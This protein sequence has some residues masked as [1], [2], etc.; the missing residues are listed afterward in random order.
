MRPRT[1]RTALTQQGWALKSKKGFAIMNWLDEFFCITE[2]DGKE[3]TV[4]ASGESLEEALRNVNAAAESL[5]LQ[6]SGAGTE[7]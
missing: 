5:G 6:H 4:T 7:Y 1:Q 2:S 3:V